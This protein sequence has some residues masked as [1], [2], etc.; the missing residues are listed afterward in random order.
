[1]SS[2]R[3]FEQFEQVL[4]VRLA[5]VATLPN[6][7]IHI[8]KSLALNKL[9]KPVVV[10]EDR[11]IWQTVLVGEEQ[12]SLYQAE[13]SIPNNLDVLIQPRPSLNGIGCNENILSRNRATRS[14]HL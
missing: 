9:L 4:P 8:F 2:S 7:V 5:P 10:D 1:M 11:S 12:R 3:D 6:S 13:G 14:I